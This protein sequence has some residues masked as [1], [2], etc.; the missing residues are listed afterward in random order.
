MSSGTVRRWIDDRG[1]GFILADNGDELF[2]HCRN[3]IGSTDRLRE[4]QR[5]RFEERPSERH[6]GKLEAISV[7]LL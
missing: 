3:L 1:F 7:S 2:V 6:Q 5:V 4:G